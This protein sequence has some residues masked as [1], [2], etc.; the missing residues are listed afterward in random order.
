MMLTS[1]ITPHSFFEHVLYNAHD[2]FQKAAWV[3]MLSLLI[4][5]WEKND[6]LFHS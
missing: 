2:L 5:K 3:K 6:S 1:M 4:L